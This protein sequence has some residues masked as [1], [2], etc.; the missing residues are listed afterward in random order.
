MTSIWMTPTPLS[1][2]L[3]R[4]T[5]HRTRQGVRASPH[6]MP[7]GTGGGQQVTGLDGAILRRDLDGHYTHDS[8]G[9]LVLGDGTVL[10]CPGQETGLG[11]IDTHDRGLGRCC[12][13]GELAISTYDQHVTGLQAGAGRQ[14]LGI[15]TRRYL[16]KLPSA[17]TSPSRS[18]PEHTFR[19]A[20][21]SFNNVARARISHWT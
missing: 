19:E 5:D 3:E 12:R 18:T 21:A 15:V 4:F 8:Q 7:E 6:S 13:A 16:V 2:E 11:G 10:A 17:Y 1:Q 20:A 9:Y 14:Q